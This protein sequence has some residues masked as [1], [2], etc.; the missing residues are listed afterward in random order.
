[1]W[2]KRSGGPAVE[3][4]IASVQVGDQVLTTDSRGHLVYETVYVFTHKED[5]VIDNYLR[6]NTDSGQTLTLSQRHFIPVCRDIES[7]CSTPD[8]FVVV[9]G[10]EVVPGDRVRVMSDTK[11]GDSPLSETLLATVT[12]VENGVTD[13]GLYAPLTWGGRIVV[14]NVVASAHSDWFLDGWVSVDLQD[15]IYQHTFSFARAIYSTVGPEWSKW[16]AED[17]G[18]VEGINAAKQWVYGYAEPQAAT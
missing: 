13:R 18:L 6:V 12:D 9:A 5:G 11:A 17:T 1:V 15:W 3:V 10:N 16:I 4:P 8:D 14:N 7:G 2:R